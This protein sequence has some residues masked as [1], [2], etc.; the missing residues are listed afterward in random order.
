MIIASEHFESSSLIGSIAS[1]VYLT[2]RYF[3]FRYFR[4]ETE[5]DTTLALPGAVRGSANN[6]VPRAVASQ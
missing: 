4:D 3:T 1:E 6:Q 5:A 2:F